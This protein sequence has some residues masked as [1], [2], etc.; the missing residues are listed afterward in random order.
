MVGRLRTVHWNVLCIEGSGPACCNV[1]SGVCQWRL[2][3]DSLVSG[4]WLWREVGTIKKTT[5]WVKRQEWKRHLEHEATVLRY[6]KGKGKTIP[7]QALKVPGGR[8]SKISTQSA[9]EGGKVVSPTHR[10]PLLHKIFLVLISVSGW[11][12]TRAI[13][14]PEGLCQWKIPKTLSEIEPVTFWLI[15]Q[16]LNQLLYR[17]FRYVANYNSA[18]Y[19]SALSCGQLFGTDVRYVWF[20][21]RINFSRVASVNLRDCKQMLMEQTHILITENISLQDVY[22]N[23]SLFLPEQS[24]M[25]IYLCCELWALICPLSIPGMK[26]EYASLLRCLNNNEWEETEILASKTVPVPLC[27]LHSLH[28]LSTDRSP[29]SSMSSRQ[30]TSWEQWRS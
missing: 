13:V 24:N 3:N 18:M 29:T 7:L 4:I 19:F 14:R 2:T 30:L 15:E 25:C 6:G 5:S 10:P 17:V 28:R 26:T 9:Y 16:C 20:L 12:D 27:P 11:V 1:L 8:G 23:S 21:Q 22:L